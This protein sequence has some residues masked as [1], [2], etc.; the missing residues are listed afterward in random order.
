MFYFF[1]KMASPLFGTVRLGNNLLQ[2]LSELTEFTRRVKINSIVGHHATVLRDF[3]ELRLNRHGLIPLCRLNAAGTRQFR[4]V[5]YLT[6]WQRRA[7]KL[8][9]NLG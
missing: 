8:G 1:C 4:Q 7:A 6:E 9:A 2:S 5:G 3:H